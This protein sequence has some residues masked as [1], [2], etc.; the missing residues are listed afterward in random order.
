MECVG[1]VAVLQPAKVRAQLARSTLDL[2]GM[3]DVPVCAGSD[4]GGQG[5]TSTAL[6]VRSL[7]PMIP[8]RLARGAYEA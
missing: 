5:G 2:L 7:R 6:E 3:H 4:G 8:W 1:V